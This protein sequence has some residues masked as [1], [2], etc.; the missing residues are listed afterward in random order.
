[1]AIGNKQ[2]WQDAFEAYKALIHDPRY[3]SEYLRRTGLVPHMIELI[4]DMR[5]LQVLDAGC[6]TGW[7]FDAITPLG[8][9]ECDVVPPVRRNNSRIRSHCQDVCRLTYDDDSFDLVVSSLV[10]MWVDDLYGAFREAYRVTRP[11]GRLI[12]SLM[13]PY[14]HTNGHVL[15]NGSFLIDQSVGSREERNVMISGIVGPLTYYSRP[16][17]DYYNAALQARW[18]LVGFRD[19][20]ID[21]ERYRIETVDRVKFTHRTDKIPLFTFFVCGKDT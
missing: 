9:C 17:V 16:L 3:D 18:R 6:G 5:R 2:Q 7:L 15:H 10:L 4:G 19:H 12:V 13:H 21:M 1:M 20:F 14:F 8:G 11:G